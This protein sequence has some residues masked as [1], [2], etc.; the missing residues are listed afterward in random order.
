[1]ELEKKLRKEKEE[2]EER[3]L[4]KTMT[5]A[6]LESYYLAKE[7]Q[8]RREAEESAKRSIQEEED[9]KNKAE[10]AS[11]VLKAVKQYMI[12]QEQKKLAMEM[13]AQF[14]HG[15]HLE[16]LQMTM[17]HSMT[18]A[19]VYS[20]FELLG[21]LAGQLS[22]IEKQNS[23]KFIDKNLLGHAEPVV[24]DH[25]TPLSRPISHYNENYKP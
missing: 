12:E 16:S 10:D 23:Q 14:L 5:A 8:M 4:L 9:R 1:M 15:L 7:E 20:Y 2:E 11:R 6:E 17:R 18:R 21:S 24:V 3:Q 13:R 22:Q 19:F 25:V